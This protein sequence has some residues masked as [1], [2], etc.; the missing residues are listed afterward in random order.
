MESKCDIQIIVD[1]HSCVEYLTKYAAKGE[2]K[3]P[4]LTKAFNS[5]VKSVHLDNDPHRAIKKTMMKTLGE[6]DFSAQETMIL[7]L[8]L[9]LYSTSFNVLPVNLNGSQKVQTL[10]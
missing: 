1:Q 5:V 7:L 4:M 3:S 10:V 2:P 9:K 6:R 8:S